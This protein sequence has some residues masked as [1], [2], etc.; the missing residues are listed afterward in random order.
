MLVDTAHQLAQPE[1]GA[2]AGLELGQRR[3]LAGGAGFLGVT[4]YLA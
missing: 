2:A 3:S 4:F 1:V